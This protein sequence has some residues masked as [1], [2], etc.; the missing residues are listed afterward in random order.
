MTIFS[1]LLTLIESSKYFLLFIG[2]YVEGSVV[3]M[4]GGI[5]IHLGSATIL[6][7][8][9]ALYA[10]DILSDITL[11]IVGYFGARKLVARFGG[12]IGVTPE[13]IDKVEIRFK[14]HH[15]WILIISKLTMGFGL[16]YATLITAGITRV[17]FW[18]YLSVNAIGG[19]VWIPFLMTLGYYF[20]NIFDYIPHQ[21]KVL[22][23]ILIPV[24]FILVF[25]YVTK[26]L[27]TVDW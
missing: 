20:G 21:F 1:H 2:S 3:M 8:F 6:K 27:A 9:V 26:R 14:R 11:Y 19:I 15:L 17:P 4:T 10:G 13:I 7:T 23:W 24:I 12:V 18:K 16:A 5:L 22:S 25:R